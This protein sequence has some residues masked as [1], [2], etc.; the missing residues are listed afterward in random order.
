MYNEPMYL[1]GVR[2]WRKPQALKQTLLLFRNQRMIS[3]LRPLT[4]SVNFFA[5]AELNL[6]PS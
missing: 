6:R 4:R 2:Q 1:Y 5:R 3:T